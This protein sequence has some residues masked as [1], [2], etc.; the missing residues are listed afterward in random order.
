MNVLNPHRIDA[1]FC[2]WD[3]F[4]IFFFDIYA[5]FFESTYIDRIRKGDSLTGRSEIKGPC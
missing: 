4:H 3:L 2:I 5:I 1:L